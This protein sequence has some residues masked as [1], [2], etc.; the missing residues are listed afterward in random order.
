LAAKHPGKTLKQNFLAKTRQQNVPAKE[1]RQKNFLT[2]T[3]KQNIPGK[4]TVAKLPGKK[5]LPW[6][7]LGSEGCEI[8]QLDRARNKMHTSAKYILGPLEK[9][10]HPTKRRVCPTSKEINIAL[11]SRRDGGLETL[12]PAAK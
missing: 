9:R 10:R 8:H 5:T 6:V 4:N 2:K 3:R 11:G 7:R 1:T 12:T